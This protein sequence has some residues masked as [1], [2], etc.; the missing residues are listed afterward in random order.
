MK[1]SNTNRAKIPWGYILVGI[2]SLITFWFFVSRDDYPIS[3]TGSTHV[4]L[5]LSVVEQDFSTILREINDGNKEYLVIGNGMWLDADNDGIQDAGETPLAGDT[6]IQN[7]WLASF[8][9]QS[10]DPAALIYLDY[11]RFDKDIDL[12]E[13]VCFK[14]ITIAK[15]G[16]IPVQ[17]AP[18]VIPAGLKITQEKYEYA[19]PPERCMKQGE[20]YI[21][22][23]IL[24][25]VVPVNASAN[26]L[27]IL[28]VK[29]YRAS[30]YFPI[31]KQKIS[32][33]ISM[34]IDDGRTFSPSME[35]VVAQEG[36]EGKFVLDQ[37]KIPT[38][39][40]D[41]IDIYSW[42][43]IPFF[44]IMAVAI[45]YLSNIVQNTS[46]FLEIAFGLL[47]GLWGTHEIFTPDYIST[48]VPID[49]IIY[50]LFI[51]LITE[52]ILTLIPEINRLFLRIHVEDEGTRNEKTVIENR[53]F[54]QVDLTESFLGDYQSRITQ[55]LPSIRIPGRRSSAR[56]VIIWTRAPAPNDPTSNHMITYLYLKKHRPLWTEVEDI[57]HLK[58]ANKKILT[59]CSY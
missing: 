45:P 46:E 40:L 2:L 11:I 50:F 34:E 1:S 29:G 38:L 47:L 5:G 55:A 48:S 27:G 18:E 15:S 26:L 7:D 33:D 54:L 44:L 35:A 42:V 14:T 16:G 3:L 20:K 32:F 30:D 22:P 9:L 28:E 17:I 31:D 39:S 23:H 12:P 10:P 24:L 8:L 36:W 13:I 41:R 25:G 58:D 43:L 4:Y 37:N 52:L 6:N 51:L 56:K 53:G 49:I 19:F 57:I 21:M 59:T